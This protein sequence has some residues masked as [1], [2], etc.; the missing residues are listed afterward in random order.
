MTNLKVIIK[1]DFLNLKKIDSI[2][3]SVFLF[4]GIVNIGGQKRKELEMWESEN[5][6]SST[7]SVI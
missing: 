4:M 5:M 1:N 3:H 2:Y 7:S 6:C